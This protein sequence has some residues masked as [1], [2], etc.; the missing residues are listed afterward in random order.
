MWSAVR[1]GSRRLELRSK[2]EQGRLVTKAANELHPD[3][4]AFT[5]PIQRHRHRWDSS[6]IGKYRVGAEAPK[7]VKV[8]VRIGV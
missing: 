1:P 2:T 6:R 3:R 4:Q 8:V 7:P 5:A